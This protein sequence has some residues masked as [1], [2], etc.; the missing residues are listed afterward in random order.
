[1]LPIMQSA[2]PELAN[3]TPPKSLQNGKRVDHK[4]PASMSVHAERPAS[5]GSDLK[6]A[7]NP[8]SPINSARICRKEG[9]PGMMTKPATEK[10]PHKIAQEQ[11]K[12]KNDDVLRV[13]SSNK[14]ALTPTEIAWGVE[15]SPGGESWSIL[16][17]PGHKPMANTSLVNAVLKRIKAVNVGRGLWLKPGAKVK[18]KP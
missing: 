5:T 9:A 17:I 14:K 13:L 2:R 18:N 4:P 15:N 10:T 8:D 12:A 16:R 3:F 7:A 11:A 1:M 6:P